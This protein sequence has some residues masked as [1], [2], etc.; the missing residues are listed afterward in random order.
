MF[1]L[2]RR[3][4][5]EPDMSRAYPVLKNTIFCLPLLQSTVAQCSQ[6]ILQVVMVEPSDPSRPNPWHSSRSS[7]W[8]WCAVLC[9]TVYFSGPAA[10]CYI[11]HQMS[12]MRILTL[13]I[14]SVKC[15]KEELMSLL[16]CKYFNCLSPPFTKHLE[17]ASSTCHRGKMMLYSVLALA[18]I[19]GMKQLVNLQ[20]PFP[21]APLKDISKE[22]SCAFRALFQGDLHQTY[23]GFF[24]SEL[25]AECSGSYGARAPWMLGRA[26]FQWTLLTQTSSNQS[27]SRGC[28]FSP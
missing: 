7:P 26:A 24:H 15:L 9:Q 20:D 4:W 19:V 13:H 21:T 17:S 28:H 8:D 22:V 6:A 12:R 5:D 3:A 16:S 18:N 14:I 25:E 11:S 27:G 2:V 10:M 23:R 1:V